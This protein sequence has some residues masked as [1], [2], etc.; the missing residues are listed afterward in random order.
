MAATWSAESL[1]P[2]PNPR[3]KYQSHLQHHH[4]TLVCTVSIADKS[5]PLSPMAEPDMV[6]PSIWWIEDGTRE[7]K[8]GWGLTLKQS[9]TEKTSESPDLIHFA[10]GGLIVKC[11]Q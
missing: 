7:T 1:V 4:L 6:P 10:V 11:S 9:Q 3:I 5:W 2:S 8:S